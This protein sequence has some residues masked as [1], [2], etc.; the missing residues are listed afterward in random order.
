MAVHL[1]HSPYSADG[2]VSVVVTTSQWRITTGTAATDF[3]L[4][5]LSAPQQLLRLAGSPEKPFS[6]SRLPGAALALQP[7]VAPPA[8]SPRLI[9]SCPGD[10]QQIPV[11]DPPAAP[12][13]PPPQQHQPRHDHHLG[14]FPATEQRPWGETGQ[15]SGAE[16]GGVDGVPGLET[17]PGAALITTPPGLT[18]PP[19]IQSSCGG[20]PVEKDEWEV[21]AGC[22]R[23][24]RPV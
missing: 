22:G 8:S 14:D 13:P 5:A 16:R 23:V 24:E 12:A 1:V 3:Q 9:I 11:Q 17:A 15:S 19:H 18:Q 20:V 4:P 6:S 7:R 10:P 2:M 21:E